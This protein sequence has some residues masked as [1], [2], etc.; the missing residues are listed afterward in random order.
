MSTSNDG[1]TVTISREA[2]GLYRAEHDNQLLSSIRK[3]VTK[4]VAILI[5]AEIGLVVCFV[6]MVVDAIIRNS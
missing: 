5:G 3:P 6:L 4:R 1:Y 2:M